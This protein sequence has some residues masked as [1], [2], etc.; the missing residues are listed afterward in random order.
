MKKLHRLSILLA[1]AFMMGGLAGCSVA[2][3]PE[4]LPEQEEVGEREEAA[5]TPKNLKISTN[6]EVTN[7]IKN[8][9]YDADAALALDL[10]PTTTLDTKN[11]GEKGQKRPN[12]S[13]IRTC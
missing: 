2:A 7:Y 11:K 8:Q 3:S 4:A 6:Q 10:R 13:Q 1:G 12:C 5:P 9:S